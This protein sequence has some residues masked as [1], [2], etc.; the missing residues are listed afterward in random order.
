MESDNVWCVLVMLKPAY[1]CGAVA[2]ARSLRNVGTRYPVWCMVSDGI[3]DECVD[4]L[5]RHF[6]RVVRVPLISHS[7]VKMRSNKQ[8]KIYGSWIHSSFTKWN[9]LNPKTFPVDKVILLDADMLVLEN[10]DDLFD[11]QAP[12]LTFSSPWAKPYL[13]NAQW[14][15]VN[16]PYMV[17]SG[18]GKK[19]REL[20]HG[21]RVPHNMIR[22]GLRNSILGLACMVL[23]KPC[24]S[25]FTTMLMILNRREQYGNSLCVSGFDEQLIA[26]TILAANVEVRHI[27]QRYNWIVGKAAWLLNGETPKTQQ[28][29][30]GK[31]WEEAPKTTQWDDI[32]QWWELA[33][34]IIDDH[35]ED[36]KWF[37]LVVPQE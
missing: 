9:I 3:S 31:P 4:F 12:A 14:P 5:G 26:E 20:Q 23:V 21:E 7:V 11:L 25:L 22:Q 16:N 10:C 33:Q 37:H 1:A 28:Y 13:D 2:V 27:H 17:P 35:P 19:L 30:H 6:A 24:E 34:S 29:Y 8:N 32:R 36:S 18:P 15:G